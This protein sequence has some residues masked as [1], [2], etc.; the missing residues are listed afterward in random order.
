[1]KAFLPRAKRITADTA[2]SLQLVDLD[3]GR[4]L[5]EP[6]AGVLCNISETGACIEVVSPLVSG[7]HLFYETL[8]GKG[9]SLLLQGAVPD[10][11]PARKGTFSIPASSVWMQAAD[12]ERPPGFRIGLQFRERQPRLFRQFSRL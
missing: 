5:T 4:I 1:M 8:D 2:V 11:E 6:V 9:C 12:E 7:R 3:S 10:R